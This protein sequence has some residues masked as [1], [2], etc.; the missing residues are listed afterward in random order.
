M[1]IS[2]WFKFLSNYNKIFKEIFVRRIWNFRNDILEIIIDWEKKKKKRKKNELILE[3]SFN[4]EEILSFNF[5]G[6]NGWDVF[7]I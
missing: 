5:E 7:D 4:G 6:E 3:F 1:M 2:R